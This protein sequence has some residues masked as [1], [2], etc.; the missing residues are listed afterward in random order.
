MI[1]ICCGR[2]NPRFQGVVG[3]YAVAQEE[4]EEAGGEQE[5]GAYRVG[6]IVEPAEGWWDG[7]PTV[8]Q[9]RGPSGAETNHIEILPFEAESGLLVPDMRI[10]L[11]ILDEAGEVVESKPLA[12]YR[13]EFY[14]YTNNFSLTS[15]GVYTLRAK[16][17]P[18]DFRRHD[19]GEAEGK[20]F[21][22]PVT[23]EFENVQ[24]S[25]EEE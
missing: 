5:V 20:V 25:I 19:A 16:L 15:N 11:T 6:Y 12:L 8:L 3:S 4:I 24:I 1:F 2:L 21:T 23:V 7:D 14:N 17:N 9:W 18:P 13:G 22:E 10:E